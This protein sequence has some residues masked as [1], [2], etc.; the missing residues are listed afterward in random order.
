[1]HLRYKR[2]LRVNNLSIKYTFYVKCVE[3][4]LL[5]VILGVPE[6]LFIPKLFFL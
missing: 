6:K 3:S 1:M 4:F 2:R 5:Y